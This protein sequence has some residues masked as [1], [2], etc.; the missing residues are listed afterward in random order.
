MPPLGFLSLIRRIQKTTS[1]RIQSRILTSLCRIHFRKR[2]IFVLDTGRPSLSNTEDSPLPGHVLRPG[3]PAPPNARLSLGLGL[4]VSATP[5]RRA[6]PTTTI[7]LVS[8]PFAQQDYDMNTSLGV[9]ESGTSQLQPFQ[10]TFDITFGSPI[11]GPFDFGFSGLTSWPPNAAEEDEKMG[12][13]Y[14]KLTFEDV[15]RYP[16]K[17]RQERAQENLDDDVDMPGSLSR[18][19]A[20]EPSRNLAFAGDPIPFIFGSPNHKTS[21]AEFRNAAAS[22]LEEM[23]ARLRGEG[24][25]EISANIVNKLHPNRKIFPVQSREIK[26]IPISKRGEITSKFDAAHEQEFNKMEGIDVTFKKR[27]Q[28]YRDLSPRKG[29]GNEQENHREKVVLGKKRKSSVLESDVHPHRPSTLP[30]KPASTRVISNSRRAKAIPGGFDME[31]NEDERVPDEERAGKQVRV[32]PESLTPEELKKKGKEEQQEIELEKEKEKEKEA[33][34]KKLEANRA[35][36]RSSAVAGRKS[37]G[38]AAGRKSIGRNGARPSISS[39]LVPTWFNVSGIQQIF[40][41][42]E[43]EAQVIS[44]R[45]SVFRKITRSECVEQRESSRSPSSKQHPQAYNDSHGRETG[46]YTCYETRERHKQVGSTF[47]CFKQ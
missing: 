38:G 19:C 39:K 26:P 44:F 27:Q 15:A 18:P 9:G 30:N 1:L 24:V 35:R 36:R 34:K 14:P 45:I 22:V 11:S 23:N 3:I 4:G 6:Q 13:I 28:H 16:S 29:G 21:N 20:S 43:T 33:I 42:S 8:N 31:E 7:R 32:D 37:V 46:T 47:H 5:S 41:F 12:D 17:P 25:D 40:P 10:T 2:T